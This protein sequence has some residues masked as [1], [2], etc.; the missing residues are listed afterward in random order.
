MYYKTTVGQ[1]ESKYCDELRTALHEMHKGV[2]QH[3]R[4]IRS[5]NRQQAEKRGV[6]KHAQFEV[7]DYVLVALTKPNKLQVR[8]HGPMRVINIK[9]EWTFRVEDLV[10][11]RTYLRHASMMKKYSDPGLL[12]TEELRQQLAHDDNQFHTVGTILDWRVNASNVVELL[13][14]WEGF[15]MPII[16]GNRCR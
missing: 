16:R 1:E 15:D 2:E 4:N 3:G 6:K 5:I 14:Q 13:I 11:G 10:Y 9:S 12:V 7:G 8:W